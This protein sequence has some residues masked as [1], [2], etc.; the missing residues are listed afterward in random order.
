VEGKKLFHL[1]FLQIVFRDLPQNSLSRMDR[2]L[3][4]YHRIPISIV[5]KRFCYGKMSSSLTTK[6]CLLKV[7]L[8][9]LMEENKKESYFVPYK[10]ELNLS[11]I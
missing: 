5:T 2:K 8:G 11:A 6:G 9:T 10:L 1:Q 7:S 4:C 3:K